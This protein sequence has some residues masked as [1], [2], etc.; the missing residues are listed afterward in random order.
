[1]SRAA[2]L[3]ALLEAYK[4]QIR[5]LNEKAKNYEKI[6]ALIAADYKQRARNL[7]AVIDSYEQLEAKESGDAKRA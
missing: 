2:A 5:W 6:N 1:M 7:Q 4:E 3:H